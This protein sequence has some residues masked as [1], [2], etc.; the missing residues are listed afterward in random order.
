MNSPTS[1]YDTKNASDEP[2]YNIGVVA[3]MT[4]IPVA[5]LRVW[6]RRYDFPESARTPGGHRLYSER[7]V[8][9]LRWVKERINEGMQTGR[10]IRAL[11]HLEQEDRL[12]E[13]PL[14]AT[15]RPSEALTPQPGPVQHHRAEPALA[16]LQQHLVAS[17]KGHDTAVAEQI[18]A[19][20]LSLHPLENLILDM[21]QPTLNHLGQAWA[22]G[23]INVAT[24]HLSSN[25]LRHRLLMWLATGPQPRRVPP[26]VL[27]CAPDEWHEGSLLMLGVLL[28]RQA[29]PVTYLGQAVPLP[30]LADFVHQVKPSAV[31][32]VSVTEASAVHLPEWPL[33]LPEAYETGSPPICFGGNVFTYQ[34]EW[35]D[36]V[37]GT[38]LGETIQDG[39]AT[40][41]RMLREVNR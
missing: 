41:D 5:T 34:P 32:V 17:L 16:G 38:F 31:V 37:P 27:A 36:R 8:L 28:R 19:E 40:L 33:W 39:L 9:R 3:R 20:A 29:W 4:D 14:T 23:E 2:L 21:I 11:Q 26:V 1:P 24:E 7:E 12:S 18:L 35:R 30:D 10:A 13:T 6:E 25:F 22:D 15:S